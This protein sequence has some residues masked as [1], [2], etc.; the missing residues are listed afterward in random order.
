MEEVSRR[1]AE[2]LLADPPATAETFASS[3]LIASPSGPRRRVTRPMAEAL[4]QLA[5]LVEPV[6][7]LA[8]EWLESKDDEDHAA[9]A[10]ARERLLASLD[11]SPDLTATLSR[12]L[13]P[14]GM[15]TKQVGRIASRQRAPNG[16]TPAHP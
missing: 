2:I 9:T 10:E 4:T 14:V 13:G 15:P 12:L 3:M 6:A 16:A 11:E 1:A 8:Q 5:E 7:K